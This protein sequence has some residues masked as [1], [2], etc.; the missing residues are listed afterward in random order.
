MPR[1]PCQPPAEH[2][3]LELA[4]VLIDAVADGVISASDAE[5]IA[6]SRIAGV[7]LADL[8]VRRRKHL[9][10]LQYQRRRAEHALIAAAA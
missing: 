6:A 8:A 10:T 2:P 9:R 7:R 5:L 3:A 1:E 4:G